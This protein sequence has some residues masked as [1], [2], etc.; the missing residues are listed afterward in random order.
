MNSGLLS[1]AIA[2]LSAAWLC[3]DRNARRR[4]RLATFSPNP[5]R[6]AWPGQGSSVAVKTTTSGPLGYD[7]VQESL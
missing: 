6:Q 4:Q 2:M 5:C 7:L 1:R 3:P